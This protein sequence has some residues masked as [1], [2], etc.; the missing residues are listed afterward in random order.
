MIIGLNEYSH[1]TSMAIIHA[2]TGSLLFAMSKERLTRRKHDGGDV[3]LLMRRGLSALADQFAFTDVAAFA[4][5]IQLVV[6]NNHHFRVAPFERRL[7]LQIA[8]KY[9]PASTHTAWNL[10]GTPAGRLLA[11][12]NLASKAT[13]IE[14]SHH[15]AHAYS[16]VYSAPVARGI[17]IVMDGMGDNRDDWVRAASQGEKSYYSEE[18]VCDDAPGFLQFPSH[19]HEARGVGYR[20]AET[21]YRFTKEGR[22]VKLERLFKR[23]TPENEPPELPNH[24]FEEMDSVGALYSRVAAIIFRDWNA[25]GKVRIKC[26]SI[27]EIAVIINDNSHHFS[28]RGVQYSHRFELLTNSFQFVLFCSTGVVPR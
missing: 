18:R 12:P 23:W 14:I 24:S 6:A 2:D 3:S 9:A 25:C 28:D 1:D 11:P 27:N 19:V 4:E 21:A 26:L 16:A 17:V 8:L 13:K 7:P 15:L 10:I 5:G 20:E 22:N